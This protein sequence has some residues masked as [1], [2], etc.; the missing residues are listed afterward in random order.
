MLQ[1]L[2]GKN[3]AKELNGHFLKQYH[4]IMWQDAEKNRCC[5]I[6]L[7]PSCTSAFGSLSFPKRQW[8]C[9]EH[10]L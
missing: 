3:L 9:V 5:H 7:F 8:A 6:E 1:T 2:Q 10:R 4:P